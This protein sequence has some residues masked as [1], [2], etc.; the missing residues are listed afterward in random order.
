MDLN[1]LNNMYSKME[2][3]AE[4]DQRLQETIANRMNSTNKISRKSSRIGLAVAAAFAVMICI[5]QFDSV[6]AA[7]EKVMEYF[8]YRFI[9]TDKDGTEVNVDMKGNYVVLQDNASKKEKWFDSV[10]LAGNELGVHLLDCENAYAFDDCVEY[11]PYL[12]DNDELYGVMLS[13][14]LYS[15]GDLQNITLYPKESKDGLD[16]MDYTAGDKYQTP[17]SAQITIRT[18]K[19]MTGE[20]YNNEIGYVEKNHDIDL[21]KPVPGISDAEVYEIDSLGVKAVLYSVQTDGPIAWGIEDGSISCTT[22]IFVYQDVEYVYMGG[23]DHAAMKDFLNT[24]K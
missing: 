22:A 3:P 13:N 20:Y 6:S 11:T 10:T 15:V 21:T 5:T 17:I 14:K 24:L 23:I 7:A 8:K 18:D 2:M 4:M 12:T 9:L 1:T 16:R 19:D